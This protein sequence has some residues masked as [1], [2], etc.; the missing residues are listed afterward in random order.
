MKEQT[1]QK[2]ILDYLRLNGYFAFKINN[3]GVYVKSRDTYI[4]SPTPGISDI[5]ALK[6]GLM[7]C[8]EVKNKPNKPSKEQIEFIE[9]VAAH[10]GI[11]FVAYSVS[12]VIFYLE[13]FK[14]NYKI[15]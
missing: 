11:G 4:K 14:S 13:T 7:V 6:N 15:G 8:I 10:G 2:S 9:N 3:G 1:I 12:D 5:I